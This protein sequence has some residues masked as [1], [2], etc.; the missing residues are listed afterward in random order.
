MNQSEFVVVN[1][2]CIVRSNWS[3]YFEVSIKQEGDSVLALTNAMLFSRYQ[4]RQLPAIGYC[5]LWLQVYPQSSYTSQSDDRKYRVWRSVCTKDVVQSV[6][7]H[8]SVME[9]SRTL[10]GA[11]RAPRTV[12]SYL[13]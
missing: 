8:L 4:S 3:G 7:S 13:K 11:N 9:P 1:N 6:R 5:R 2:G 10:S 12:R